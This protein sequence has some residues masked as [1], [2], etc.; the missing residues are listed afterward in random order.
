MHEPGYETL[1][2][3]ISTLESQTAQHVYCREY[4]EAR[5]DLNLWPAGKREVEIKS[6]LH[7]FGEEY[8]SSRRSCA[9]RA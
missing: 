7:A 2:D 9:N 8:L 6:L 3:A 4:D 1:E 5:K